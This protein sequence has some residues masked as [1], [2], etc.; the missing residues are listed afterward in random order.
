MSGA[1]ASKVSRPLRLLPLGAFLLMELTSIQHFKESN[2]FYKIFNVLALLALLV[3]ANKR[4]DTKVE[5]GTGWAYFIFWS[6]MGI[7]TVPGS[8]ITGDDSIF[9]FFE[10][11]TSFLPHW[12]FINL[13][14]N[15]AGPSVSYYTLTFLVAPYLFTLAALEK[16][17]DEKVSAGS[18]ALGMF[19]RLAVGFFCL[20]AFFFAIWAVDT[21]SS[22]FNRH[23]VRSP[24]R[25]FV[26][27]YRFR[28]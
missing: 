7:S 14:G 23:Q 12:P 10:W 2:I 9:S 19:I 17:P 3:F 1:I 24:T 16:D 15:G 25:W 13:G 18:V 4:A 26:F 22:F 5:T 11:C 20:F 28:G 27:F 8:P 6:A 21:I